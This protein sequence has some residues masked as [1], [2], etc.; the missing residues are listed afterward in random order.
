MSYQKR[1][2]KYDS[3]LALVGKDVVS[4][5]RPPVK[6]SPRKLNTNIPKSNILA[7]DGLNYLPGVKF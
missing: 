1:N 6:L 3:N 5:D 2:I 4:L 7:K